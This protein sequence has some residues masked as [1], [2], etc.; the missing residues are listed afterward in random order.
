VAVGFALVL[1]AFELLS[2]T[3]GAGSSGS[4]RKLA[5]DVDAIAAGDLNVKLSEG[6][7]EVGKIARAVNALTDELRTVLTQLEVG[8]NELSS[9]W[10]EVNEVA[11][12]MLDTSETTAEQ[13]LTAAATATQVSD[14]MQRIAAATEQMASTIREVAQHAAQAAS[15]AESVAQEVVLANGTVSALEDSSNE[16]Q[17]VVELIR[18]IADQ[19]HLLALNATIEAGRAGE[20]GHGFAVVAGE[21]K[22]LA[23]QTAA[24]TGH[25]NDSVKSIQSGSAQA[26]GVMSHFTETMAR[27]SDNQSAIAAAVEEQTETTKEIGRNTSMAAAGSSELANNVQLL[28]GA[29][30]ATAYAGA[31]ARTIAGDLEI[32]E[33][34]MAAVLTRYTFDRV[35]LEQIEE[36]DVY[37][38]GVV[39]VDGITTVQD[40]V[41]GTDINQ[42]SYGEHWRHSKKTAESAE[43]D[44]YCSIPGDTV[45]M[46]FRGTKIRYY[47]LCEPNHGIIAASVDGGPETMVDQYAPSHESRMLWESP[48]LPEGEHTFTLRVTGDKHPESRYIWV[49]VDHVDIVH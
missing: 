43:S 4:L 44:S 33:G 47:G 30:R 7:G 46:R 41:I 38:T 6:P 26:S 10:R 34:T 28:V 19:T 27:V 5:S 48:Q 2:R 12:Q 17:T 32:L 29:V 16:I 35:E 1:I 15:V 3:T 13:A 8:K 39:T 22:A 42:F 36:E 49:T 20:A 31:H 45:T 23:Q 9:G 21:V 18:K 40:N 11:W 24:A 25:V 14:T 37:E